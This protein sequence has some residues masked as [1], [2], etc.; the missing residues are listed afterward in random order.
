MNNILDPVLNSEFK[1]LREILLRFSGNIPQC[2]LLEGGNA[3]QRLALAYWWAALLNCNNNLGEEGKL[4]EPCLTCPNCL[5]ILNLCHSDILV[6]D[7]TIPNK[8]DEEKP[9][10]IRSFN[11][12]NIRK[13]KSV[14]SNLPSSGSK[15][16]VILMS[17]D[18][19]R[20]KAANALLKA[21]EEPSANNVFVLLAPQRAQLL[22]TLVSRS[23][24]LTLPWN[25]HSAEPDPNILEWEAAL[26]AFLSPRGSMGS[27]HG[28]LTKTGKKNAVD[29]MLANAIIQSCQKALAQ[30]YTPAPSPRQG[31]KNETNPLPQLNP[32]IMFFRS[33]TDEQRIFVVDFLSQCQDAL[34]Y[35]VS[36][37]RVMDWLGTQL[38]SLHN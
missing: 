28:W 16:V 13:L 38:Y 35:A 22:P 3:A 31:I 27:G 11:R 4:S 2:L 7:G 8:V 33:L 23:W 15:R 12:P 25:S 10:F 30:A 26:G 1:R 19:I 6:F 9:G 20:E 24:V 14:L 37:A 34:S 21:L 32:L 29:V 17:V 18:I 36:P 5:Q